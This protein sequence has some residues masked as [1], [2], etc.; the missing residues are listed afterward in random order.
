MESELAEV[1]PVFHVRWMDGNADSDNHG[2]Y[3]RV[4]AV[5]FH[6]SCTAAPPAQPW[7]T[8]TG[9]ID[10]AKTVVQDGVILPYSEVN[11][12]R[13]RDFLD[14]ADSTETG[15]ESRLGRAMGRVLAHELYHVLL[16]TRE[17]SSKGIGKAVQAPASL[18]SRSLRFEE[19]ELELIRS[20]YK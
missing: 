5:T 19:G 12:D 15:R 8:G 20:R 14:T 16:Q 2:D 7:E 9:A 6:G 17:H 13:V 4:L 11:C 18:L 1:I 10:L 3:R